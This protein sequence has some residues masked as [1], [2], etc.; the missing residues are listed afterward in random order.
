MNA[1]RRDSAPAADQAFF[2]PDFCAR[3]MTF[4]IIFI[5]EAVALLLAIDRQAVRENFW[6]DITLASLFLLWIG[7]GCAF[8]LCRARPWLS[9]MPLARSVAIALAIMVGIVAMVS[10]VTFQLGQFFTGGVPGLLAM[11]P[12]R[13]FDFVGRNAA[14]GLIV[15]SLALR[16][17]YV[18]AEWKR[19]VELEARARIHALQA[20]IRPHFLFNSMNTIAA[21]TRSDPRLAEEAVQDLADLF[22][23]NLSDAR[24]RISLSEEIEV[25]RV[26]QRIESLRLGERLR[27][28]W[29]TDELP[30]DAQVPSLLLQPLLENAIYHGVERLPDGGEVTIDGRFAD[31]MIEIQVANPMPTRGAG[32]AHEGNKFALDNIAQRLQLAWPDRTRGARVDI[33]ADD[34]RFV[35]ILRF[36]YTAHAQLNDRLE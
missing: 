25:A 7:L 32:R 9:R 22:R 3:S 17:F 27:V 28:T 4:A 16:Y 2:L 18:N 36:P 20:R 12:E 30:R 10:E 29:R 11:F 8:A 24:R 13:H 1:P 21:L 6:V 15:A 34:G 33:Q 19:S 23:A 5:A 35:V 26:Y 31:D 14:I